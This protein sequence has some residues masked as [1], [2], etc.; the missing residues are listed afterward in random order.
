MRLW[1]Q[2]GRHNRLPTGF[3]LAE[4]LRVGLAYP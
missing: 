1:L 2:V 4:T 3:P